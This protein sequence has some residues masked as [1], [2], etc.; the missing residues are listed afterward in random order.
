MNPPAPR[1][2]VIVPLA[3]GEDQARGL[4]E[5]LGDHLASASPLNPRHADTLP[6]IILV[7]AAS[8]PP[9][10]GAIAVLGIEF[11]EIAHPPGRAGQ[12]NAGAR[13]ARGRWLWFLHADS[14]MH[15]RTLPALRAFLDRGEDA[16][17]Y[18]DLRYRDDGPKLALINALGANF[19]ARYLGLPFGDQGFVLPG[20]WF[21]RIGPYDEAAAYGEDH[22]LVWR[23]HA[24]GLPIR[25]IGA[26]LLSS[27]RN[28]ARD[29]WPRTTARHLVLTARQAW[30]Q[31]RA[32]TA[33]HPASAAEPHDRAST[34]PMAPHERTALAIF[35]KTPG[36]SPIKTR[37]AATIGAA[38]AIDFHRLSAAAIMQVV[39]AARDA[40]C[41][42]RPYWA[43]AE[44]AALEDPAWRALP[45]IAQGEGDLGER[46][47]RIYA[48]LQ[49]G[50]GRVLLAGADAPQVT[51]ALLRNAL[52]ALDDPATP[53]VLGPARD[54]GF[55]LFGGSIPIPET[56]WRSVGYSR[57]RTAD[58]L[59]AALS[60]SGRVA[61]LP[62]LIDVDSAPDLETLAAA[63]D[64]LSE[65]LPGQRA[66][67]AW[68]RRV[69]IAASVPTP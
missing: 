58:D 36:H 15:P 69:R 8:D 56:V 44:A 6:E 67:R 12:L 32:H 26:P 66:L 27:A 21:A 14:R 39:C 24:A 49:A 57:S 62:T 9:I 45:R 51:I 33:R 48:T 31:W 65:P 63:L 28:Y 17:G 60:P 23:A 53:F 50:H 3:P 18:F 64:A 46:L 7:R 19:R 37:L 4:L 54:G 38:N 13:A 34:G 20:E 68:W 40:G 22:L 55:W 59:R 1:L 41:D 16:L 43:V 61:Q 42:L 30:P 2:S 11:L 10:G 52:A 5:Q 35:V 47:H 25:P 29:G